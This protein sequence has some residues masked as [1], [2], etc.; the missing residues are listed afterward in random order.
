MENPVLLLNQDNAR[1]F[2]RECDPEKLYNLFVKATQIEEIIE[3][4]Q[5]CLKTAGSSKAHL[6]HLVRSIGQNQLEVAVIKEKHEKLQS[7][8]RLRQDIAVLTNELEWLKVNK[9]ESLL[10]QAE[11]SVDKIVT[12]INEIL[13][14][15][16]NK[17]KTDRQLKE[18]I[19]DFGTEFQQ[20]Q[21]VVVQKDDAAD[22]CRAEFEKQKDEVSAI[23]NSHRT[24]IT[25]KTEREK[26]I[27][28]LQ[29]EIEERENNPQN[30]NKIRQ[31]NE[32]K[33]EALAKK[34]EDLTPYITNAQRDQAQFSESLSHSREQIEVANAHLKK[35]QNSHNGCVQ[36]IRLLQGSRS[37]PLSAYGQSMSKF[38][39]R[40]EEMH[41]RGMF[42]ELP[43]GPLGRY[44]EVHDKKFKSAVENVLGGILQAFYVSCDKDRILIYQQ[45][46]QFPE[47]S[48]LPIITC[49]FQNQVYDVR[50]GMVRLDQD[51]G[52]ILM[53]I[54]KVSDPVVMNCLIDQRHIETVVFAASTEA[55]IKITQDAHN[56]PQNLR[57]VVLL[58]PLSEYFP[59]PNYR[60]YAMKETPARFIQT[61]NQE[62]IACIEQQKK[63]F[64]AK[65]KQI[66]DQIKAHQEE[67]KEKTKLSQ[68]KKSLIN[69]LQQ[70]A[71]SYKREV[72][73]LK[74][75]EYPAEDELEFLRSELDKLIKSQEKICRKFNEGEA[76]LKEKKAS[77]A[78][79]DAA[80]KK[81]REQAREAR[82]K[83]MKIQTEIENA[84]Q[85]LRDMSEDIKLKNNQIAD[86]KVQQAEYA[87]KVVEL[88]NNVTA[89]TQQTTAD[90]VTTQRSEDQIQ[91][92]IQSTKKRI[93]NIESHN[94]NIADVKLLLQNKMQQL[95]KM[96]KC[97]VTL[98]E[99]LR[100]VSLCSLTVAM[101]IS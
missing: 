101:P 29:K 36:Q 74:A 90:R 94:D 17:S 49:A 58:K 62:V 43:R 59:A 9:E 92:I 13:D 3:K 39:K 44:I 34:I 4:L 47:L 20:L 60:S 88:T 75:I 100:A 1:S 15:V 10:K 63:T 8:A 18:K 80:L 46:K 61:N 41:Q 12:S 23:E 22:K 52:R 71:N 6:E 72:N 25:R 67:S 30:V 38:V 45:L 42:A 84:Q 73:E 21:G 65:I 93:Q 77:C 27:A 57:R 24:V 82:D 89:L 87:A 37:D 7:V 76:A 11:A 53:D 78:E 31:E 69:E 16:K 70:K 66:S 91:K 95:D 56:V 51:D 99:V 79:R 96:I 2:L 5:A 33:I 40:I 83:M 48:R 26:D 35:I 32:Q 14:F 50:N 86:L 97:R 85:Q 64:E 81:S 98:T 54:I 28:V 68:Q 55:A 19:R